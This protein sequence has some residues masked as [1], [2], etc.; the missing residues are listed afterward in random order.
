MI[1]ITELPLPLNYKD[2][3]IITE[4]SRRLGIPSDNIISFN[5]EKRSVDARKKSNV[6]FKAIISVTIKN[7]LEILAKFSKDNK[8]TEFIPYVY[9]FNI[10]SRLSKPPVI[11][12][13]GPAGI[14]AA[15]I[16]ARAGAKPI[17]LERGEDV[18]ARQKSIDKFWAKRVLNEDSNV[19]FG[20]GG[21]GTF[22]DGKL[23]T[24]TKDRRIRFIFNEL[25]SH[26]APKE[27]LWQA[28]PHIG[29]DLLRA[30]IK[31]IRKEI[32]SLG[33]TIHFNSK[34]TDF[35][36]SNG[37]ITDVKYIS[38]GVLREIITD[39]LL[40]STGHSAR[41]IF[42]L[43]QEKGFMLSR[44]NFSMGVR[45]EH[46]CDDV[47]QF[48]YGNFA[49]HKALSA[50]DYKFSIHLPNNRSLYSFCMC[51]GGV[52]VAASS[53]KNAVVTNGMSYFA[54]DEKNSN[55][56]LL[57]GINPEDFDGENPLA[58]MEFQRKCEN[59]AFLAGGENYSAPVTL[60]GDFVQDKFSV[61]FGKVLPSYLPETTFAKPEMYLP[62]FITTTLRM[63]II[64][65]GKKISFLR[66]EDAVLTGVESRSS[67][68][69]RIDRDETLQ[70][71]G[72][73]GFF[74]CGEGAGY[75]GGIISAAVDGIKCAESC[76]ENIW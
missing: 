20:E 17:I 21:A 29:T 67:S 75:A 51:P 7:E 69:V 14:F 76:L 18:D 8:V 70:A 6:H 5:L 25:V 36:T 65:L 71:V 41:D 27:I 23:T 2:R 45:I 44:K 43:L 52:V 73:K 50:A 56:A 10:K 26:G 24:G 47:N 57:V 3:T 15:L 35:S 40:L 59:L 4:I 42:T 16:L 46:L 12:G 11:V 49:K 54:R 19:Q 9:N 53:E 39:T 37:K 22:S 34:M 58:G 38:D 74:P 31:N 63:G 60:V 66:Q 61:N 32:I 68:P 62:S 28:K 55:S 30:T 72:I 48:M 33:G 64:E 1:K 13:F